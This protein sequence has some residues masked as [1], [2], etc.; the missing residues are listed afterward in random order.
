MRSAGRC[1]SVLVALVAA[2][3]LA[4]AAPAPAAGAPAVR[5]GPLATLLGERAPLRP[6]GRLTTHIGTTTYSS[7][8]TWTLANSPYV[9]DGTVTVASG[10]TLTIEPG[11]VVKL[12]GTARSLIV[13]GTL[14]AVGTAGSHIVFTSYQDDTAGGDTNG[15]GTATAGAPGQWSDLRFNANTASLLKYTARRLGSG[16][17]FGQRR[18]TLKT[19]GAAPALMIALLG[20]AGGAALYAEA[21]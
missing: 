12:N 7:N 3:V 14:S 1:W 6:L 5:W 9:L 11:V 4:P 16:L 8:T 21:A 2:V 17:A 18:C 19:R 10:A 13:N 20:S 15:D